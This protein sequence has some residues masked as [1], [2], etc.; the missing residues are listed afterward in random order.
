MFSKP[1]AVNQHPYEDKDPLFFTIGRTEEENKERQRRKDR[2]QRRLERE[3]R[4]FIESAFKDM[5][6]E[7]CQKTYEQAMEIL[8]GAEEPVCRCYPAEPGP[9]KTDL[10][11]SCSCSDQSK[12]S[13]GSDTD[14]DEWIV[15]FTPPTAY[16]DP[17]YTGKKPLKADKGT[18]YSYMDYRVKLLDRYGN[19]VPRFFT[20][21]DGKQQCSDLGGFWSPDKTWL[22]INIDG[23]VGPDGRWAPNNFIGPGGEQV[24]AETGK[25]QIA[26]GNWLVVGVDGYV[27]CQ[28]KW[29][30]YQ[31]QKEPSIKKKYKRTTT[32][33]AGGDKKDAKDVKPSEATW[34][35]FGDASPVHL[36]QMGIVG[37]GHDRKLLLATLEK[38]ME[39]GD[40]VKMPQQST[41]PHL[42]KSQ[43]GRKHRLGSDGYDSRTYY[44][45]RLR[46]QHPKPPVKG[47][48]MD[49]RG[50]KT[51][52]RLTDHK[53]KR[54]KER[55]TTLGEQGISLS[56]FHV[57]CFSSFINSE[58]MKQQHYDR[59]MRYAKKADVILTDA[60][61]GI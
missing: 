1:R 21:P 14:D 38:M 27:D 51:Y 39:Q 36:S 12:S 47:M 15:E 13:I 32:G 46:C 3:Q 20:G 44:T 49:D 26:N 6:Q 28:N 11:H 7:I 42:P 16:F 56:S 50:H 17:S 24:D 37:H 40:D 18:L 10:E 54:P 25:F 34:S 35:C 57:P 43:R 60:C 31:K 48:V 30:Y 59:A 61:E 9:D 55:L 22:E 4:R 23:Y 19:A 58:V 33:I 45:D 53:N 8:P 2:A 52:F 41:V 5:C 29:R